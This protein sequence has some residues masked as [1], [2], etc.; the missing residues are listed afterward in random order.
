VSCVVQEITE[1]RRVEGELRAAMEE[2]E[3]ANRAKSAF[4]V[5]MRHELWTPLN[6]VISYSELMQDEVRQ[7]QPEQPSLIADLQKINTAGAHLSALI[8]DVLELSLIGAREME[9]QIEHFAVKDLIETVTPTIEPM[10]KQRGNALLVTCP[11]EIGDMKSDM[12]KIR[13]VL[14]NLMSNAAKFTSDGQIE[15]DVRREE[16]DGN[17]FITFQVRDTGIGM[18]AEQVEEVFEPFVHADNST[19]SGLRLAICREFC[20]M[21]GGDITVDSEPGHGSVFTVRLP[22][23]I[24]GQQEDAAAEACASQSQYTLGRGGL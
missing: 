5:S 13:Q 21:L 24:H 12:N 7:L 2:A 4:L 19:T 18:S 6:T 14:R 22:A 17:D 11:E 16:C 3:A 15:V 10:A 1:L 20:R 8:A 9:V 23:T